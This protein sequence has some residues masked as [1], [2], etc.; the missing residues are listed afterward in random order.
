[1][2]A[3]LKQKSVAYLCAEFAIDS[4]LPTYSGGLGILAGDIISQ[5]GD[6]DYPMTGIGILYK[7]TDFVQHITFDGKEEKRTS[8]FDHDASFLRHV[9]KNGKPLIINLETNDDGLI[10][11]KSYQM[12]I[13]DNAFLYFLSSD[14][15]DNNDKWVH[16]MDKLYGG[17]TDSQIRQQII[18][19]VGGVRLLSELNKL[20]DVYHINEGRPCFIIWEVTRMLMQQNK[21][22][23][24]DAWNIAKDKI[25]YTN[26]TLVL[27]GNLRYPREAIEYWARPYA[28]LLGVDVYEIIKDGLVDNSFNITK[29]ALNTSRVHSAVSKIHEDYAKRDW[30]EY[31]WTSITNGVYMP[32]WQDSDFRKD[33]LNDR[34]IWD[35]H[36]TK[37]RELAQTVL[38]RTGIGYDPSRLVISWA[39]RLAEYKQPKVI[40]SDIDR[41]KK[42]VTDSSRPVQ[43]LFAGNSHSADLNA[44][45]LIDELI[46]IFSNE[47]SGHA[48][49]IPDYNIALSNNLVSGS[50]I[51]LN[52][53]M[54]NMEASGT[55]GMKAIANGV[56]NATVIDGWT[57]EVEWKDLGWVLDKDSVSDSFYQQLSNEMIPEYYERNSDNLPEKW[58]KR[59][60]KSIETAA[61]FSTERVLNDYI[62]KLYS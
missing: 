6:Q 36:M 9:T 28:A 10:Q 18:L 14:I 33:N 15:D 16:D 51:W 24:S 57:H 3:V 13:S 21:L 50:D 60:R 32:R 12:R 52:T 7:G 54:G 53:P 62:K 59:M 40:F 1:M 26:H 41:L 22:T 45:N 37:K 11:V 55:S 44:K 23:F 49:F 8:E 5:A 4:D 20:P 48:I 58:I 43:L 35:L 27:A 29:F 2:T 39:R 17:D 56:L 31:K 19:G 46:K 25:V 61:R 38:K 34:Q 47:L 30:P 42:L